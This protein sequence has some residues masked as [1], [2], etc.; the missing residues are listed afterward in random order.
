MQ[1]LMPKKLPI[2]KAG[3]IP[4]SSNILAA[5][6]PWTFLEVLFLLLIYRGGLLPAVGCRCL[7]EIHL[8]KLRG[9]RVKGCSTARWEMKSC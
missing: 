5:F 4:S 3:N 6:F 8:G 9:E 1:E 2:S 7:Q